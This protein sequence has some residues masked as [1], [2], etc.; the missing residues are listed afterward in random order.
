VNTN[1][2]G[3]TLRILRK[4]AG[5]TTSELAKKSG[6]STPLLSLI[7]K[8]ERI[9]SIELL[10]KISIAIGIPISSFLLLLSGSDDI[11]SS[12]PLANQI[13]ETVKDLT[14]MESRLRS[15]IKPQN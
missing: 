1:K 11:Q 8:G 4:A 2:A 14:N 6:A 3:E 10:K 15:L 7:E 12:D 9:P 13:A 5:M